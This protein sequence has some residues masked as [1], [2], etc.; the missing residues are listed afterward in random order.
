VNYI[1]GEK[2]NVLIKEIYIMCRILSFKNLLKYRI[3]VK[4]YFSEEYKIEYSHSHA[5]RSKQ[6]GYYVVPTYVNKYGS[7][8][9]EVRCQRCLIQYL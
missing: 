8:C 2:H 9:L 3:I 5:T 6:I 4:H 1:V 7:R